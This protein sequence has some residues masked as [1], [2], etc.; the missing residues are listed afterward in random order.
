MSQFE[1][2]IYDVTF[3]GN[4]LIEKFFSFNDAHISH[5]NKF[6]N[7]YPHP[8]IKKKIFCFPEWMAKKMADAQYKRA[9][10]MMKTQ[11]NVI[12]RAGETIQDIHY[13]HNHM[14]TKL[15]LSPIDNKD[16]MSNFLA[17]NDFIK[18][19]ANEDAYEIEPFSK[20]PNVTNLEEAFIK[21]EACFVYKNKK[22]FQQAM[23]KYLNFCQ[24]YG[25]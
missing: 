3:A 23:D 8:W 11:M 5:E 20:D 24:S 7:L 14:A 9:M 17:N 16:I 12:D 19:M 15:R 21:N 4:Y 25:Q 22:P 10:R 2:N 13:E 18:T 6:A 1:K